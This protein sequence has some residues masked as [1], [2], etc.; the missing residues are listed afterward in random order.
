MTTLRLVAVVLLLCAGV[1]R[2]DAPSSG[3]GRKLTGLI[4]LIVGSVQTA[5]GIALVTEAK[6]RVCLD[7][8]EAPSDEQCNTTGDLIAGSVLL[9]IGAAATVAGA[10]LFVQG[11]AQE[12]RARGLAT[13]IF[14]TV[15]SR[16]AGAAL[17][18]QF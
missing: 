5:L 6:V 10:I 16:G 8:L 9:P 7:C 11:R 1:A 3:R 12:R 17:R 18:L 13:T 4:L 15:S 2:A 14:P